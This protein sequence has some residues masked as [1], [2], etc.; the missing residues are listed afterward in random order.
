MSKSHRFALV[1]ASG[2]NAF[3]DTLDFFHL[4]HISADGLHARLAGDPVILLPLGSQ[5][6]HG[7]AL[8][9]GDY[10][11]AEIL[12]RRIAQVVS[13]RGV[14]CFTAPCLPFG[15]AD[16]FG[17]IPGGLALSPASFRAVLVD[18]IA[19]LHQS[20]LTRV[21]I[22]NGHG[23]NAAVIHEV[24][25][26]I[27]QQTGHII[28]SFYLWK[29][30]RILMERAKA[31]PPAAAFGHGGEPLLS[32]TAALRGLPGIAP[33]TTVKPETLFGLPVS[34]FG[35][36]DFRG[37]PI[38]VPTQSATAPKPE[39]RAPSL[40]LGAEIAATLIAT[41]SDFVAHIWS[42]SAPGG[43]AFSDQSGPP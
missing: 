8:P 3:M 9:M 23:G 34:G 11:T 16:Y 7:P 27:R 43:R 22:L 25:L 39:P 6:S 36:L 40:A 15:A 17:D 26:G 42:L 28:P 4:G 21:I 29:I 31:A 41:A 13:A 33:A 19:G 12:A 37:L 35:T 18:L 30:A 1:Q 10:L 14:P 24:T 38:E 2:Q 5:E 20:G 32:L